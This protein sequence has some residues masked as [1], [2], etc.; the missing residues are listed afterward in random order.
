MN[1]V[2]GGYYAS[3]V[4]PRPERRVRLMTA[5]PSVSIDKTRAEEVLPMTVM[6]NVDNGLVSAQ[7]LS[8]RVRNDRTEGYVGW[9][10]DQL[11]RVGK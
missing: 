1:S 5:T 8:I 6:D 4:A 9:A 11:A 7:A 10:R 3:R 2:R